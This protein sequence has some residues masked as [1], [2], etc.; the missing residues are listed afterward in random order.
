MEVCG[1]GLDGYLV[2]LKSGEE[3][4]QAWNIV[5]GCKGAWI[6]KGRDRELLPVD[7]GKI[8]GPFEILVMIRI[9]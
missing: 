1:Q 5:S 3:I 8:G 6:G 2:N 4:L 9:G 7:D